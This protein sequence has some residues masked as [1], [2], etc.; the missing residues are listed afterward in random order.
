MTWA[1]HTL[2]DNQSTASIVISIYVFFLFTGCLFFRFCTVNLSGI[3]SNLPCDV[4]RIN[5]EM[6]L[7]RFFLSTRSH[8]KFYALPFTLTYM[9]FYFI[10]FL[11]SPAWVNECLVFFSV[12]KRSVLF[13]FCLKVF[14]TTM[15]DVWIDKMFACVENFLWQWP[16]CNG[17]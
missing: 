11:F 6:C 12:N 2:N 16:T 4:C 10:L 13:I 8:Y 9:I 15:N 3:I 1:A 17:K 14:M 5:T 7:C